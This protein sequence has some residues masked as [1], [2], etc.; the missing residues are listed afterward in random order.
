MLFVD[1]GNNRVGIGTASPSAGLELNLASGDG[2]LINSADVGTIKMK[3]TAGGVKNWGFA[4]TNLA[5]SDFGI[6]QSNAN[7]GDPITAGAAKLYF[8]GA[9]A[10]TF[11][12]GITVPSATINGQLNVTGTTNS[13]NIFAQQL[14]TQ[15]D[16]SSFLRLHPNTVTNSGGFTNIFFGTSTSNNY[17]VAVGGKR[18]GTDD[19]PSFA[20]R[21]LNDSTTGI[22]VLNITNAGEVTKPYQPAFSVNPASDQNNIAIDTTVTVV[23]GTE[24][25]DI[26]SNF[27]SNT[28]T[29]PVTGKYQL[30]LS[31]RLQNGDTA[32]GFYQISFLTSNRAY[33]TTFILSGLSADPSL[34]ASAFSVLADMDASDTVYITIQQSGGTAQADIHVET[35]FSGYL[36]A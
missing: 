3:A 32:A 2:L 21:T 10:A 1:G 13:N 20:V 23:F 35:A 14:S 15:F 30:N 31:L 9:G 25:F 6:Y 22:E 33:R 34:W 26:G 24:V 16:T 4:T 27:A 36:V 17:G 19:T 18:S 28:F 5:A 11:S 7:G 12:S 29:A 8:N